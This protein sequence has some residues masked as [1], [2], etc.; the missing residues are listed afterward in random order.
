M[1]IDNLI[2]LKAERAAL[3]IIF[4][5]LAVKKY[6]NYVQRLTISLKL[7]IRNRLKSGSFRRKLRIL[8]IGSLLVG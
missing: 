1:L 6:Y 8:D 7:T 3:N 2:L 5:V 4:I